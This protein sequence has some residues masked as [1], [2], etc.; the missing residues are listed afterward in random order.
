[1]APALGFAL[2]ALL[3]SESESGATA[4]AI[5]TGFLF[6]IGAGCGLGIACF[7]AVIGRSRSSLRCR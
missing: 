7:L 2:P 1:M 6:A 5:D 4:S 3:H